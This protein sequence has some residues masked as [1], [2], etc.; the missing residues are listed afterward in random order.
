M[1]TKV[2]EAYRLKDSSQLWE[3]IADTKRSGQRNVQK[4]MIDIL[5]R[6]CATANVDPTSSNYY[7][8]ESKIKKEYQEGFINP[9]WNPFCYDV[10]LSF[11]K[12]GRHHYIIPYQDQMPRFYK[13]L[14]FLKRDKRLEPYHYWNNT[15]KDKKV[16]SREWTA[17]GK[18]WEYFCSD[19]NWDSQLILEICDLSQ[20]YKLLPW[21]KK[22]RDQVTEKWKKYTKEFSKDKAEKK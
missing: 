3:F 5:A 13:V 4:M 1:S 15:D 11:R 22:D 12:K 19:Y 2:Y 7:D 20:F 6:R 18:V 21:E 8:L 10:K 16:S 14:D 17:R 9:S